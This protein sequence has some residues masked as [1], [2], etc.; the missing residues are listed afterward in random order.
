MYITVKLSCHIEC[1][2]A[3]GDKKSTVEVLSSAQNAVIQGHS[4]DIIHTTPMEGVEAV[5]QEGEEGELAAT[6]PYTQ[7]C[8][9]PYPTTHPTLLRLETLM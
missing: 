9:I 7:F 3:N 8:T 2:S 5:G 1:R 4:G 6:P